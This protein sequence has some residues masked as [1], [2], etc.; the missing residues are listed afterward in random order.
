MSQPLCTAL[1][2]AVLNRLTHTGIKPR[3]VAGHSSGEIAAAYAAGAISMEAAIISAYYRGYVTTKQTLDGGMAAVGLGASEAAEF[4]VEG[5]VIACENSP[6]SVTISG[7]RLKVLEVAGK[8]KEAMPDVLAR[9]LKVNMAYHSRKCKH[10]SKPRPKLIGLDH[11]A[12]LG[13]EYLEHLNREFGK[14]D[15]QLDSPSTSFISSV[16]G[17]PIDCA[18]AFSPEY[19]LA[20]LVSPVRFD[21]AVT[22][23]IELYGDGVF[24]E[25][26]PH[27][28]LAGPL[29]QICSSINR[30]YNYISALKRG[31][32]A[33]RSFMA[34]LGRLFQEG[35]RLDLSSFY[36]HGKTLPNLPRYPWD[37]SQSLW[38]E[39]RVAQAWRF[40]RFAHHP[41]LGARVAESPDVEP[42]WRNDL[43]MDDI[44]WVTDHRVR[45]DV[46]FPL[47]AY[48]AAAGEAVRQMTGCEEGFSARHI[49][50]KRAM[51]LMEGKGV[52]IVTTLRKH[53]ITDSDESGW[54][55]FTIMSCSGSSWTTHCE[56]Q[57]RPLLSSPSPTRHVEDK[58]LPRPVSSGQFYQYIADSGIIFG[59]QFKT[60][61]GARSSVTDQLVKANILTPDD[62]HCVPYMVHP[63]TIDACFQLIFLAEVQG[64]C[65]RFTK[66]KLPT[67]IDS[68]DIYR[69]RAEGMTVTAWS[70][71]LP[72]TEGAECVSSDGTTAVRLSGFHTTPV[73]EPDAEFDVHAAAR[74]EW[75]PDFD[76]ADP[77][78]LLKPAKVDRDEL[79]MMEEMTFLCT[80]ESQERLAGKEPCQPYFSKVRRWLDSQV[81]AGM[82][83]ENKLVPHAPQLMALSPAERHERVDDLYSQ[84]M[85]RPK[86]NFTRGIRR[87]VEN[88]EAIFT[89]EA[90]TIDVLTRDGVLKDLYSTVSFEY[91]DFVRLLSSSRPTLRIL[92]VGA[93]TG[94]TTQLLLRDL[95]HEGGLPQYS[96][97]TFTDISAGFFPAAKERFSYAANMEYKVFD[98]TKDPVEQGFDA[99]SYDLVIAANVV[100]AT[101]I[102]K[103]S[104]ANINRLLKPGGMLLMT[105]IHTMVRAITYIFGN[106]SGWWLGDQDGREDSPYVSPE[107]WDH[108]LRAA[109]YDGIDTIVCDDEAPYNSYATIL[110]KRTCPQPVLNTKVSLISASEDSLA[111]KAVKVSLE[112]NG[113][114]VKTLKLGDEFPPNQDVIVS[115]DIESNFFHDIS[116]EDFKAFQAFIKCLENQ[117]VLWLTS[118]AQ[119][120]CADPRSAGTIGLSRTLRSEKEVPFHTLEINPSDEQLGSLVCRV[121]RKIRREEDDNNLATDK[122]FAV[123][124]GAICI[125][126]YHPFSLTQERCERSMAGQES[127]CLMLD[128][129]KTGSLEVCWRESVLPQLKDDYVQVDVKASGVNLHDVLMIMG[130]IP[131]TPGEGNAGLEVAG[132][133]RRVGPGVKGVNVGD[134]VFGMAWEGGMSTRTMVNYKTVRKIPDGMGFTEAATVPCVF[135]TVM[136]GLLHVGRLGRGMSVLIHSACGGVGLAAIQVARMV[137]AEIFVTVGAQK[138]VDFLMKEFGLPRNRIFNSRN[139]SFYDDVMRETDGQGVDVVLNSLFGNLLEKSWKCVAHFGTMVEIGKRDALGF[140]KLDMN[141]FLENR[142]YYC[143]D[144]RE[145]AHHRP[146]RFGQ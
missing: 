131:H 74:L 38:M 44:P 73:E 42:Q 130:L 7:D 68:I 99:S 115:V 116:E 93:G 120:N 122:E 139:E 67:L 89:G 72:G 121:F 11:M 34:C 105:E 78:P 141:P 110:A 59:P 20:N 106:F 107:R 119:I 109:G 32:D 18:S 63:T 86:A 114:S 8:I 62:E 61:D 96:T 4:L 52:E 127:T 24:L 15:I 123:S 48:I 36:P 31:A 92:E 108:D 94:G 82:A 43:Y 25:I 50:A 10:P 49:V 88:C 128:K 124:D 79:H 97:Y 29:R 90:E 75:L 60:L 39:S 77:A 16:T 45:T 135:A 125:S 3:A 132:V 140:A 9:P 102:L 100:H 85:S 143:L 40:R 87:V 103:E 113:F 19:W 6:H 134:R 22:T 21:S 30:P 23:L 76:F 57:V 27:S 112:D 138:K 104:L 145:V 66:L 2:I 69:S 46:V 54:W 95:I 118:P 26:G 117:K 129:T 17:Y 144:I 37:H 56:G 137:G 70:Q 146:E 142:T 126:R 133:V 12:A 83:G 98:I 71:G 136:Q 5:V 51:V 55:E 81:D 64:L 14:L 33:S 111:A 65:R 84:L 41:L 80:L 1:Q 35:V 47:A 53:R 28:T 13:E 91:G 58:D 101:P